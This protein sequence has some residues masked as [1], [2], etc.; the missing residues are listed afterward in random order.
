MY[1]LEGFQ[2]ELLIRSTLAA[3]LNA[4]LHVPP[5]RRGRPSGTA[6]FGGALCNC[7]LGNPAGPSK[8]FA[9]PFV[10]IYCWFQ[11]APLVRCLV[12]Y[13]NSIVRARDGCGNTDSKGL[14]LRLDALSLSL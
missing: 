14:R 11:S 13:S 2:V 7:L 5:A 10:E 3:R 9:S 8:S 6:V 12:Q 4:W 1:L